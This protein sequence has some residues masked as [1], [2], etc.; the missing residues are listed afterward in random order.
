MSLKR[1]D[2]QGLTIVYP[3]HTVAVP[4][5]VNAFEWFDRWLTPLES[6]EPPVRSSHHELNVEKGDIGVQLLRL[7]DP[8]C[9]EE[10]VRRLQTDNYLMTSGGS[11]D[12]NMFRSKHVFTAKGKC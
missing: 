5:Y 12:E 10:A 7:H 1:T 11:F 2:H 6:V 8:G 3:I 4:D 9:L